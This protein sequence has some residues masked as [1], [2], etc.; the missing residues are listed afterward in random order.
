[1]ENEAGQRIIEADSIVSATG[2][3]PNQIFYHMLADKFRNI[4]LI[5]DCREPRNIMEAISE[6]AEVGRTL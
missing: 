1:M 5:G 2:F 4:H 3:R 6:G